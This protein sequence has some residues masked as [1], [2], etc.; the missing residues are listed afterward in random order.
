ML[1]ILPPLP[2]IPPTTQVSLC[3]SRMTCVRSCARVF[4]WGGGLA[5]F[6]CPPNPARAAPARFLQPSRPVPFDPV[7]SRAAPLVQ[8]L[9]GMQSERAQAC[10]HARPPAKRPR[11]RATITSWPRSRMSL[12]QIGTVWPNMAIWNES[13]AK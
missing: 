13:K 10:A 7:P 1:I 2:P 11:P 8:P 3:V 9:I 6:L 5:A 12:F 4:S